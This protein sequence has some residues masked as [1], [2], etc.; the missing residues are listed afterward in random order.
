MTVVKLLEYYFS[1]NLSNSH[2]EK[3][4]QASNRFLFLSGFFKALTHYEGKI[5]H[6]KKVCT[7]KNKFALQ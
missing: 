1:Y 6:P 4:W 3:I 5:Q 2:S 7:W